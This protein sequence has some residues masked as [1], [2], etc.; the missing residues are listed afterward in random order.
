MKKKI[1]KNNLY[2]FCKKVFISNAFK[3][4]KLLLTK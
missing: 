4:E 1:C 3:G 2:E